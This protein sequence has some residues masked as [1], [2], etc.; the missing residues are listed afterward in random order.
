[1]RLISTT[2]APASL[3][4]PGLQPWPWDAACQMR[5]ALDAPKY[6]DFI[7]PLIFLKRLSDVF[8]DELAELARMILFFNTTAPGNIMVVNTAKRTTV[9]SFCWKRC[10]RWR[11]R[12]C[13]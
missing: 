10:C 12:W 6:K 7:L 13:Y 4:L 1:M 8:D 3:D 9:R 2:A 5:G 11:R